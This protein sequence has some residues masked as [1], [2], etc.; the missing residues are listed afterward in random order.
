[1]NRN[2]SGPVRIEKKAFQYLG[3]GAVAWPPHPPPQPSRGREVRVDNGALSGL[4]VCWAVL[5]GA[6]EII[7]VGPTG[8]LF[9]VGVSRLGGLLRFCLSGGM[10]ERLRGGERRPWRGKGFL[11]SAQH[12]LSHSKQRIVRSAFKQPRKMLKS[13][14]HPPSCQQGGAQGSDVFVFRCFP[15]MWA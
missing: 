8:F 15:R 12:C 2:F 7:P 11:K 3:H 1:M 14:N 5:P 13:K 4:S 9:E 10:A 6:S